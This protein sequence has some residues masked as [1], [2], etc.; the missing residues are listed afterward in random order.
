MD[1]DPRAACKRELE[2]ENAALRDRVVQPEAN[3]KE[4]LR[5]RTQL[6]ARFEGLSRRRS[7]S[8]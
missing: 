8:S 1:A 3:I 5:R 2:A 7:S 4:L 6:E